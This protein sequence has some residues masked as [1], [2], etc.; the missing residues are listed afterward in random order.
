[1]SVIA[2]ALKHMLASGMPHDAIIAAVAEMEASIGKDPVAEKRREYDRNRRRTERAAARDALSTG[3]QRTSA[4]SEDAA[5]TS[6]LPPPPPLSPQ[7]PQTPPPPPTPPGNTPRARKGG[8]FTIPADW[9]PGQFGKGTK[10]REVVDGWPPGEL[11]RQAEHFAAHH[12]SK[13]SK[14]RD[15]QDA[16]STWVLNSRRFE[17]QNERND[18]HRQSHRGP[19]NPMVRAGLAFESECAARPE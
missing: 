1:M 19:A 2:S 16:W 5:D 4:E 10:S 11:E 12:R 15:W 8:E 9:K 7:T 6:P 14:F 3:H 18:R 17:G 13:G